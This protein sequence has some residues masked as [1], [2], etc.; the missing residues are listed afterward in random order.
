MFIR[1]KGYIVAD[2]I[3]EMDELI[4]E[5]SRI[6][7]ANIALANEMFDDKNESQLVLFDCTGTGKSSFSLDVAESVTEDGSK[8]RA[9]FIDTMLCMN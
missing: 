5:L 9:K 1:K 8:H 4:M 2:R 7:K 3:K 6:I